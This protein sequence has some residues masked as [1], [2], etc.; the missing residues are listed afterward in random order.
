MSAEHLHSV[1]FNVPFFSFLFC[2]LLNH[3]GVLV[4]AP[5][6]HIFACSQSANHQFLKIQVTRTPFQKSMIKE[7][8]AYRFFKYGQCLC[9][10]PTDN[11]KMVKT[12][13]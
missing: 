1:G 5:I 12:N 13:S 2:C 10:Q 6:L 9:R 3:M 7:D 8:S 11:A 4:Y